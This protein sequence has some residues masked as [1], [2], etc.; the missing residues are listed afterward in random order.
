MRFPRFLAKSL[1]VGAG[2]VA[3]TLALMPAISFAATGTDTFG[4]NPI[5]SEVALGNSDLRV[6]VA[7]F[8]QVGLSVLGVIAL[9]IVLYGGFVYMTAGGN[10]D[11]VATARKI[12]V[13][14]VIGLV[15]ILSSWGITTFV[16]SKLSEATGSGT[17]DLN[18]GGPTPGSACDPA[19]PNYNPSQ[20]SNFCTLN[21]TY[22]ACVD[23]AF[24]VKSITPST[25]DSNDKTGMNNP[26]V[27]V[28]FSHPLAGNTNVA[29]AVKLT[30][31]GGAQIEATSQL[32]ENSRVI[33]VKV[34]PDTP[35]GTLEP[36]D[37]TVTVAS[38]LKDSANGALEGN[39]RAGNITY[40]LT[41]D[42][43][44]DRDFDDV[45]APRLEA[46]TLN[47]VG[48]NDVPV[49]IGQTAA[50]SATVRDR[51]QTPPFGGTGLVKV[52]IAEVGSNQVIAESYQ[53]PAQRVGSSP[54]FVATYKTALD[55]TKFSPLKQYRATFTATDI[56][57]NQTV[58]TLTFK[59][60]AATCNNG[61][62]D[63]DETG[64]DVGGSCGG[65][66]GSS[67]TA[68]NQCAPGNKCIDNKC[69]AAPQIRMVDPMDG[70]SGS[71]VTISGVGFG[72]NPG[73]VEFLANNVWKEAG[74]VA[75]TGG[76]LSWSPT[77]AVVR[78]PDG[79]ADTNAIRLT[80]AAAGLVPQSDRSDDEFGPK[81]GGDGLFRKSNVTRPALCGVSVTDNATIT[82]GN[83]SIQV[84]KGARK[85]PVTTP[86]TI[87]G[88]NL[89][90]NGTIAFGPASAQ[91]T[92]W[93][94]VS[95]NTRVPLNL[96]PGTVPVSVTVDGKTSNAVPFIV[97]SATDGQQNPVISAIDPSTVT[98]RSYVT[99][100]GS[101]F[102]SQGTVFIAS[103]PEKA[104][105]CVT[106]GADPSCRSLNVSSFPAACGTTWS[107][108]QVIAE[109]PQG[110]PAGNY[111]VLLRNGDQ[112]RTDGQARLQIVDGAPLPSICSVSPAQGPAPL[113]KESSGLRLVGVNFSDAP[114]VHFWQKGAS[115]TD[116][117]TWLRSDTHQFA[118]APV[119]KS[120][121]DGEIN[122]LLP[123]SNSGQTMSS[124]PI[125]VRSKT[126]AFSNSVAYTV[127]DCRQSPALGGYQCCTTGPDAGLFKPSNLQCSGETR[128]A[129]YVWRFTT[130]L[131]PELPRVVEQCNEVDWNNPGAAVDFPSPTPWE[132][133]TRGR[134][135]CT[136]A[137]IAV[138]FTSPMDQSTVGAATVKVLKCAQASNGNPDCANAVE[139]KN[140]ALALQNSA[141]SAV[142]L[143]KTAGQSLLDAN[144][145]Y[146]V[147]LSDK[148][149][150]LQYKQVLNQTQ[151]QRFPL[152]KTRPCGDGTAYCFDFK[153]SAETC[154]LA[155]A[156]ILPITNTVNY[157]G[158]LQ[159]PNYPFE[160]NGDPM[161]PTH[162]L[163]YYLWG[164]T[165]QEC[166]VMS[167]DG[168]GWKWAAEPTVK[169]GVIMAPGVEF[170]LTYT[171]SRAKVIAKEQTSPDKA[172][173]SATSQPSQNNANSDFTDIFAAFNAKKDFS[174]IGGGGAS[175]VTAQ[176]PVLN[177]T[178]PFTLE[179]N[180]RLTDTGLGK[181]GTVVKTLMRKTNAYSFYYFAGPSAE[182]FGLCLGVL[183]GNT[184]GENICSR[185]H[186]PS[187]S[188]DQRSVLTYDGKTLIW[189]R[190]D[191]SVAATKDIVF[192]QSLDLLKIGTTPTDVQHVW[193]R[194]AIKA[195]AM[196]AT[197]V[198]DLLGLNSGPTFVA[199]SSLFI[200]LLDP[201][202]VDAGPSC[203]ESCVNTNL[204]ATFNRQMAT[205]TFSA[206]G[207]WTVKECVVGVSG[208]C[209]ESAA[210]PITDWFSVD[211]DVSTPTHLE[212]M[213]REG[214]LL[215]PNTYYKVTLGSGIKALDSLQPPKLG[216][217]L[218]EYTWTFRTQ[219]NPAPCAPGSVRV[220]P[221]PFTATAVGQR[222]IY[223]AQP[224]SSPNACSQTGQPLSKW[225]YGYDWKTVDTKV[226]TVSNVTTGYGVKPF[227]SLTCLPIG[228][229]NNKANQPL[230]GNAKVDVGEDCDIADEA[231]KSQ[232]ALN[233]VYTEAKR[234][235]LGH[236]GSVP[237][238]AFDSSK[239]GQSY[240][241][242]GQVT[243]GETCD[244]KNDAG[245]T[246]QCLRQ[247]TSLA[248]TWC[249]TH[250]NDTAE[251][252]ASCLN[253]I[254]V[255]G[256]GVI[257][258]GEMCEPG[259]N[260]ADNK[261]CNP[262][263]CLWQNTC[264]T[265]VQQCDPK[266]QEGC[267]SSCTLAGS[268]PAYLNKSL[269]GDGKVGVGEFQGCENVT[270]G[271][272]LAAGPTQIVEAV[273]LGN[274]SASS[275]FQE[276]D[277]EARLL[278]TTTVKGVADYRLQ[279]GYQEFLAPVSGMFNDCPQNGSSQN[280]DYGVNSGSCCA[281][282]AKR[283][284]E[285]PVDGTGL[286]NSEPACRNT[287]I[288]AVF[289]RRIRQDSLKD[290]VVL[291]RGYTNDTTAC[292]QGTLNVT[293]DMQR[294][295]ATKAGDT[296]PVGF[297]EGLW[298][299]IKN[300]FHNLF[301]RD[302]AVATDYKNTINSFSL[303]CTAGVGLSPATAYSAAGGNA[304]T[305]VSLAIDK[306]L[307]ANATFGVWVRGGKNGVSDST[308]VSV[309]SPNNHP[310]TPDD[311]WFFRTGAELCRL[312]EVGV[313]PTSYT[314]T[315]PNTS[316]AFVAVG[317]TPNNQ[318]IVPTPAYDWVWSWKPIGTPVFD[319][320]DVTTQSTMIASKDVQGQITAVAQASVTRDLSDTNNQ[321]GQVFGAPFEL[322]AF[323]CE[324]PWP[325]A[326]SNPFRDKDFNFAMAYCADAG[327][328]GVEADDLP[329]LNAPSVYTATSTP[330]V[331]N[332]TLKKYLF[333]NNQNDDVIGIQIFRNDADAA[334]AVKSLTQW[335][336]DKFQ[337]LGSMKPVTVSG[338][339]A[340][341]DGNNYYISALNYSGANVYQ[342]IYLFSINASPQTATRTV[343]EKMLASLRFNTNLT[344][345]GYCLSDKAGTNIRSAE[346]NK[347]TSIPCTND[348][349]CVTTSGQPMSGTNGVCSNAKTKF[350]RDWQRLHDVQ[351]A[352]DS[353]DAYYAS[354]DKVLNFK[355]DL[356][357]GT[358]IPGYTSSR[359]PSW[360]T[361]GGLVGGLPVDPINNWTGCDSTDG[362]TC[363]NA[364]TNEFSCPK[365]SRVYEYE[366]VSSTGKYVFHAPLEFFT[367]NDTVTN[368]FIDVSKFSAGPWQ[369]CVNNA[370]VSPSSAICGDG[371]VGPGEQCDP[372][373]ASVVT[374]LGC[375]ANQT[376]TRTCSASCQWTDSACAAAGQCGNGKVEG[377]EICDEGGVNGQSGHCNAQCSGY[378]AIACG[379][380]TLDKPAEF[381]EKVADVNVAISWGNN[382][383]KIRFKYGSDPTA[384]NI[385]A[386]FILGGS[387]SQR[388]VKANKYCSN[389]H[390]LLCE[391]NNDCQAPTAAQMWDMKTFT[392]DGNVPD[393]K[394]ITNL[395]NFG[396]CVAKPGLIGSAY[397]AD[398]N[399]SCAY[400]CKAV[401]GSCGDK[402]VQA[403]SGEE[404]DDGNTAN[405]DE[406][407]AFCQIEYGLI[408]KKSNP[409]VT[410]TKNTDGVDVTTIEVLS[411]GT[412]NAQCTKPGTP[413]EMCAAYSGLTGAC[414][415]IVALQSNGASRRFVCA[416]GYDK[417]P[418]NQ[419][420]QEFKDLAG[421]NTLKTVT[422]K[423]LGKY[424]GA[425][426]GPS[427]PAG[428]CGNNKKDAGEACD[429][430]QENG[431]PCTPG[432][433]TSCQYCSND[434]KNVLTVDTPN[435]CGNGKIDEGS[436]EVCETVDGVA[437]SKFTSPSGSVDL[438]TASCNP[439]QKGSYQCS[440]DCRVLTNSCVV[441][442]KA[443][444]KPV[445]RLSLVNP[446]IGPDASWP[447]DLNN[448]TE[449]SFIVS[450][451]RKMPEDTGTPNRYKYL[452]F[453][454]ITDY[455]RRATDL[456]K[457]CGTGPNQTPSV[458]ESGKSPL[459]YKNLW[460]DGGNCPVA[461]D[462]LETSPM[463]VSEYNLF[464]NHR[465]LTSKTS[466][467]DYAKFDTDGVFDGDDSF[468]W[469]IKD[470]P[471]AGDV[472]DFPVGGQ[473]G[474]VDTQLIYSPAVPRNTYRVVVRWTES[475]QKA[476]L[477]FAGGVYNANTATNNFYTDS[478]NQNGNNV[479]CNSMKQQAID[480]AQY[481]WPTGVGK[482]SC[483]PV[484][485]VYMHQA[486][487]L[488]KTF[489][490]A[491]TINTA[492]LGSSASHKAV[493]FYVKGLQQTI[494]N[495]ATRNITV[496][497][498][499]YHDG[500]SS[501]YSVF[502]PNPNYAFTIKGASGSSAN[503]LAQYWHVF[504]FVYQNGEYQIKPLTNGNGSIET[505]LCRVK[506]NM[507]G[508]EP[509][510]L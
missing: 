45:V 474:Q 323:F 484:S 294:F 287:Y 412:A 201:A 273:G 260:G 147:Q 170:G 505:D 227:C 255:C 464:F 251:T 366:F 134:S 393:A 27:R 417:K 317:R 115:A 247:G 133:T 20:C 19:S 33:E 200:N 406:C 328:T 62:Q 325:A 422:I 94:D 182:T 16:L 307:D 258:N 223:T 119:V 228:S 233:C 483:T 91:G 472:F 176:I 293:S 146:R 482:S 155:G 363:W 218:A 445:P 100:K 454:S 351:L 490:Q 381:C 395:T 241:G 311:I 312:S 43:S 433:G 236:T 163:Y 485:G 480:G 369:Q 141:N 53:A 55:A 250:A 173:V 111:F 88:T 23:A 361:L 29:Q 380:G 453:S 279:C 244:I 419:I 239:S 110:T 167:A 65:A 420:V 82:V 1:V 385:G 452:G 488:D 54:D 295:V 48:G 246:A 475:E 487:G 451:Y 121:S 259:L 103:S 219:N 34:A 25:P 410:V 249:A 98:P 397:N 462:G 354:V 319:I 149:Q 322:T 310:G 268:S 96:Q 212:L 402:L 349:Q 198:R 274:A 362:Q 270:N 383:G 15:I 476:G 52:A 46:V 423:C 105:T 376:K 389:D 377:G 460:L 266:T 344:D 136:N 309:G 367:T 471:F 421:S 63:G 78:V 428:Q 114:V 130:G 477:S 288:E 224:Y 301:G 358:F 165:D 186:V 6:T 364:A 320:P 150:S 135:A 106:Q 95:I 87:G 387:E 35:P 145:W 341:S 129:G 104:Q 242:D 213:L 151:A 32:I 21:P 10:E 346:V 500:Q 123:V 169:A 502:K 199:T 22:S 171:D 14:G 234:K 271:A 232:C 283:A 267:T 403:E 438:R 345:F 124:G 139:D 5:N 79:I 493:A 278:V 418:M 99:I 439:N 229:T 407:S 281:L 107:E 179:L 140:L 269:C 47:G 353:L 131:I 93:I 51:G 9:G 235:T 85:A 4:L 308:G 331:P 456:T 193:N 143:I 117:N 161:A 113:P 318:Q 291:V 162:P 184:I 231:T 116:L 280:N 424:N 265:A 74:V 401:G 440:T 154:K 388:I 467:P 305:T 360:G 324:R 481:W 459:Q 83:N 59:V 243:K 347:I 80:T 416:N 434:C 61:V 296:G 49:Y 108:S 473:I 56:A 371:A 400:D 230:C 415:D 356:K 205:T 177:L 102:S 38:D 194:F 159:S 365:V 132:K 142:L 455:S 256:N 430:G 466:N 303:W 189:Y 166:S 204:W 510:A 375:P 357:S 386:A 42:F 24:Y 286:A 411:N 334:G 76:V 148:I 498:Y 495:A 187:I 275:T 396:T 254:S 494:A 330:P 31:K 425:A 158:M 382:G 13:N 209:D 153:T 340:L 316:T 469:F 221:Q 359:W 468:H 435:F 257:E 50:F 17:V 315:K 81:P 156:N 442:G 326:T 60:Y 321:Q 196:S 238:A 128:E 394:T 458:L 443:A 185:M 437:K 160:A 489:V 168:L 486:T 504:N 157:L 261:T 18:G 41:A 73:K 292:P 220:T 348:L 26:R 216:K 491:M 2:L 262:Q 180:Y 290:N 30:R 28:L 64:V 350:F 302:G 289:P 190:A 164:K 144:T 137:S 426:S 448:M 508:V 306:A 503:P 398:K 197:Q 57:T 58:A 408:C 304:T 112:Q 373:G 465:R 89:G 390:T 299:G 264:G 12:L 404:C 282:R 208:T 90:S 327:K 188:G 125:K 332:D 101:G 276:T 298:K 300:F 172:I 8:I 152:Q 441:C 252:K 127:N 40:P 175:F 222:T 432:Y 92:N 97:Q 457:E 245:C 203:A 195:G 215:K 405:N 470:H 277:V 370:K 66:P 447:F 225:A 337:S 192:P 342:N 181:Q 36:G 72:V 355:A 507:P 479:W 109:I 120:S 429:L 44:V 3:L 384:D 39:Y 84:I 297:W 178:Q 431:K 368:Q 118:G 492:Q 226:A 174:T 444:G 237:L 446:M 463:C 122:T 206:A 183:S 339:E 202:V 449:Q 379:N 506:A 391:T 263:S 333:F 338:Y 75:C 409:P 343:F 414:D 329:Y 478:Y 69:T 68:D 372:Q 248:A 67:C 285:Y 436:P 413:S 461:V 499:N 253:S 37:Y 374:A 217:S 314:F 450:S 211:P 86:V 284:S 399:L 501:L 313:I 272:G 496:E 497:V 207:A 11:K 70:A 214:R 378:S 7:K 138:K 126:G 191:G 210:A 77:W 240:C 336:Q 71:W 427:T 352:Q 335:Y 392:S 509:C